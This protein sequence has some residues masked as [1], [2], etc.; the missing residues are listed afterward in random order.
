[1]E[2]ENK[3]SETEQLFT[4]IGLE[5]GVVKS[6]IKSKKVTKKLLNL[7]NDIDVTSCEKALGNLYY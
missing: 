2:K 3:L 6:T 4:N 7:L 5:P 1:M